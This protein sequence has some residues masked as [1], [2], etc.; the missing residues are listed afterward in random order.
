MELVPEKW[1]D[2]A[3]F[4]EIK[5]ACRRFDWRLVVTI[6]ERLMASARILKTVRQKAPP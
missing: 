5:A 1:R 2:V 3:Q 4:Y 6:F